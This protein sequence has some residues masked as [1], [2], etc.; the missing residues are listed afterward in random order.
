MAIL[1]CLCTAT[2]LSE[3]GLQAAMDA[4]NVDAATLWAMVHVETHG[5]GFFASRRPQILF[6]RH[7]FSQH[8]GGQYDATAPDVSN[9]IPGGY[10]APGDFQYTRLGEAYDLDPDAALMSASWG[11]G[12][13]MGE[14][15]AM[16]G[17]ASVSDMVAAMVSSEDEQLEAVVAFVKSKNVATALQQQTWAVYAAAYNGADYAKYNY[18]SNLSAAY[19]LFQDPAKRPDLS[20][21]TAQMYL[22]LL[23]YNPQ[24]VDGSM[25]A[26]TLTA[27]HNFQVAQQQTLSTAIDDGVV[28][29]LLAAL[30]A[31]TNLSLA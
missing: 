16:V 22:T 28:A 30:P 13:V 8:T 23:G 4:L 10:G 18:D 11:L 26:H 9:P 12:Q 25:G 31:A 21:R 27:L 17:Y 7:K 24:G 20:V 15:F 29:S 2:P 1:P 14:N 19:S 5:C 3:A 6:E